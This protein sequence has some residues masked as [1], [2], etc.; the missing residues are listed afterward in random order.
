MALAAPTATAIAIDEGLCF[1]CFSKSFE[2]PR[3]REML[4]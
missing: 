4:A 1:V 3:Q 2:Q